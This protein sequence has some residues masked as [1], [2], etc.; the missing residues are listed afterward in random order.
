[1][2]KN[3]Y[4]LPQN[5]H[6]KFY[7]YIFTW[8]PLIVGRAPHLHAYMFTNLHGEHFH[9]YMINHCCKNLQTCDICDSNQP[10]SHFLQSGRL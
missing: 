10:I 8:L 5:L 6:D 3:I 7:I 9:T 1:M 4:N 2:I